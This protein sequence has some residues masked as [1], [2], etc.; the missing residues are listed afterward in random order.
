MAKIPQ[1][2]TR[3]DRLI[4][5][6]TLKQF[7]Y[8]LG[9]GLVI[10]L[11]YQYHLMGYLFF[12]EFVIIALVIAALALALAFV[13]INGLPFMVFIASALRF[14]L[15]PK[16]SVWHKDTSSVQ[17]LRKTKVKK[18]DTTPTAAPKNTSNLETLARVLDTGGKINAEIDTDRIGTLADTGGS[19]VAPPPVEDI[20][21]DS[22]EST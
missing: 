19:I 22:D 15:S 4:G 3:E 5:P 17:P 2:V 20:L 21:E 11:V 9:G 13:N 14:V 6:L 1:D 8:L 7:L 10:F 16:K 12:T 18:A